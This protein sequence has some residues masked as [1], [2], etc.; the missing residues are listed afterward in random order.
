[1]EALKKKVVDSSLEALKQ[2]IERCR[3]EVALWRRLR[4]QDLSAPRPC[5]SDAKKFSE[6]QPPPK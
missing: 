2:E 1:M 6:A 3:T 4:S 5:E